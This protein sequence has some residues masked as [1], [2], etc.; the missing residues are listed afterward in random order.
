MVFVFG[1]IQFPIWA[2]WAITHNC[3][4]GFLRAIKK[5]LKPSEEWGPANSIK[6]EEW[7][8]F[9]IHKTE[10][11]RKLKDSKKIS[12]AMQKIYNLFGKTC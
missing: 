2:L 4:Q 3:N 6:K 12:F 9:K 10:E 5:L 8:L 11:R 7:K 1:L